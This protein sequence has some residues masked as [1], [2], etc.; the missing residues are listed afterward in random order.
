MGRRGRCLEDHRPTLVMTA[1]RFTV[2]SLCSLQVLYTLSAV[3]ALSTPS[4]WK[5]LQGH[6]LRQWGAVAS[7]TRL[8]QS[9]YQH[10]ENDED[11]DDDE[12]EKGT[13]VIDPLKRIEEARIHNQLRTDFRLFLTQRA[14]QSFIFLLQTVRDPHTVKWL[15]V[16]LLAR[17]RCL[18][19]TLSHYYL[20]SIRMDQFGRISRH[21]HTL[22]C[23]KVW[24]F[25][26]W[27]AGGFAQKACGYRSG[28]CPST[29]RWMWGM[30]QE[31]S[32]H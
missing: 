27:S 19:W 30:V 15:E 22:E 2:I 5:P 11:E 17:G 7:S 4:F 26:G 9:F 24:G 28:Q 23:H 16:C 31:Q 18:F 12:D 32:L 20:G 21:W 10:E 6:A 29:G 3:T 13:P 14:I 8:Y 25:V 1:A